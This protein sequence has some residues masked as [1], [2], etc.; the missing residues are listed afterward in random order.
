MRRAWPAAV[1]LALALGGCSTH[2]FR[3]EGGVP[4]QPLTAKERVDTAHHIVV[5]LLDKFAPPGRRLPAGV[6][7]PLAEAALLDAQ[8]TR[9]RP[10]YAHFVRLALSLLRGRIPVGIGLAYPGADGR[11]PD[12]FT[13]I[14]VARSMLYFDR[15]VH[16]KRWRPAAARTVQAI[17]TPRLGWTKRRDGYAVREPGARRRYDIALTAD[18]GLVLSKLAAVGGGALAEQYGASAMGMV[19]RAQISPGKWHKSLGGNGEMPVAERAIALYALYALPS[20]PD[21]QL[22][23]DALPDLF[24]EAF[25]PWGQ[26]RHSP[27][28]GKRG[29]G[30]VL[31]L[32]SLYLDPGKSPSEHVTR[33][34]VE[35]RRAD[36]TFKDAADDDITTQAYFA[37][38]FATRAYIY[39]KGGPP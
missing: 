16:G 20:K 6:A 25:E 24:A 28:V 10:S 32:R 34:F 30:A 12:P 5:T 15:V 9:Y 29:I 21:Q 22:V 39:A 2:E 27:V 7:A 11:R 35:H 33:W 26:P 31:A 17:V 19:R 4:P 18:A 14:E 36:G 38:A 13:T 8:A 23:L 37:L 1:V 3:Y